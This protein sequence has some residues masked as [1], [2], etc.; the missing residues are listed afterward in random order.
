MRN[1]LLAII[2]FS[3]LHAITFEDAQKGCDNNI[4]AACATLG[5][6]Y[7]N[8]LGKIEPDIEKAKRYWKKG[9]DLDNGS[10]CTTYAA[11]IKDPTEQLTI[12]KKACKLGNENGCKLLKELEIISV[13]EKKC[14]DGDANACYSLAQKNALQLRP[15]AKKYFQLACKAGNENGCK[16]YKM[17]SENGDITKLNAIN[18]IKAKCEKGDGASCS[19]IGFFYLATV[20]G[21]QDNSKIYIRLVSATIWFDQ[22]CKLKDKASCF[23]KNKLNS[24]LSKKG[25]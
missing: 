1:L 11:T 9:C 21:L 19:S 13:E 25:E 7:A 17:L 8:G 23:Y 24:L 3:N 16:D 5:A 14:S 2:V 10:A 6:I 22:G 12:A 4:G 15:E 18:E 20:D